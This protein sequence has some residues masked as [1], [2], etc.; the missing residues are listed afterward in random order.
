MSEEFSEYVTVQVSMPWHW[1]AELIAAELE[2]TLQ[3]APDVTY[4]ARPDAVIKRDDGTY[5]YVQDKTTSQ[6]PDEFC[7]G[8]TTHA[9]LH[10][11]ALAVEQTCGI[12]ISGAYVQGLYKGYPKNGTLYSPLAYV[13]A[14]LAQ[15]GVGKNQY[16][17]EYRSGWERVPITTLDVGAWIQSLPEAIIQQQFPVAGPISINRDL[18]KTYLAQ[19]RVREQDI[20]LWSTSPQFK[21]KFPQH[22]MHCDEYSKY[23]RPCAW[24]DCCWSPVVGRDPIGSGMYQERIPHHTPEETNAVTP[25]R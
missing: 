5:W 12:E 24:R 16:S 4:M 18:A 8:W 9:E 10:A 23:R 1:D 25:T 20:K 15:P 19:V 7:K 13:W 11:T 6:R 21:E 2:C 14:K 17:W 3:L 22:F